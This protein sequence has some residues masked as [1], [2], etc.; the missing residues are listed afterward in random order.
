MTAIRRHWVPLLCGLAGLVLAG[1]ASTGG[2]APSASLPRP[3]ALEQARPG[4]EAALA[5]GQS[6]LP[7]QSL[8]D[9]A[10]ATFFWT[11]DAAH[12]LVAFE[13]ETD[14]FARIFAMGT[15]HGFYTPAREGG[16]VTGDPFNR[17]YADAQRQLD[18][19]L[20]GRVGESLP[21]GQRIER[22][23]M[24]VV[25]PN[26]R[27]LVIPVIGVYACRGAGQAPR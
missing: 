22:A 15:E 13:N 23:V 5:D 6:G 18:I 20:S 3:P 27:T 11:A 17:V 24:R 16:Y 4:A 21:T 25:Q 8:A 1:C 9:G 7:P 19:R 2:A 26:G 14:G 10:C 12:R